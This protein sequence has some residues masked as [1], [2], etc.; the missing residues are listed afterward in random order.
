MNR[1][2]AGF[3]IALA[4]LA[5]CG[6]DAS[7]IGTTTVVTP[8]AVIVVDSADAMAWESGFFWVGVVL[9]DPSVTI[10]VQAIAVS[11]APV[12]AATFT[13]SGCARASASGNVITLQ[14][15]DCSG[16]FGL[17]N[18]SGTV[19]FTYAA[20]NPG[21]GIAVAASGLQVGGGTLGIN[22][23]GV[24]VGNGAGRTLTINTNSGGSGPNGNSLAR[25]GQYTLTWNAG[26]SCANVD[27]VV[28]GG[29]GNVEQSTF[30]S[31]NVCAHGCPRSGLLTVINTSTGTVLT[32]T[33]HGTSSVTVTSQMGQPAQATLTC[34]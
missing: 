33:F 21:V 24:L 2:G 23:S 26:D 4:S 10:D 20:A 22:A 34:D 1:L 16:P 17:R 9:I 7:D 13:P 29:S 15:N 28:T 30:E 6:T 25:Q 5:G 8:T 14:L 32:T 27:G 12:I 18:V 11:S 3:L 19:T 31:F